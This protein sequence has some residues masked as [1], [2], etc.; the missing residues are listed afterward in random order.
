MPKKTR[1]TSGHREPDPLHAYWLSIVWGVLNRVRRR[2]GAL[3]ASLIEELSGRVQRLGSRTGSFTTSDAPRSAT[4]SA[5]ASR[6][7]RP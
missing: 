5:P 1:N 2:N 3:A 7:P 6:A 4:S